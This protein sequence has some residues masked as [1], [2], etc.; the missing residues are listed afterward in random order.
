MKLTNRTDIALRTLI[1]LAINDERIVPIDEIVEKS[2]SH[3]SQVVSAVQTMRK[4]GYL[5]S[6]V[7]RSGGIA[8]ARTPSDISVAEI[9][10]LIEPDFY[11]TECHLR[12]CRVRCTFYM[13]CRLKGE[14]DT[15]L[16]RF[17]DHLEGITLADL[18]G[19]REALLAEVAKS[20]ADRS[21]QREANLA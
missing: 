9:V 2:A 11:L 21:L 13:A 3:R 5:R 14:F 20:P 16:A 4:N 6:V 10:K 18:A 19:N 1:Y 15:A 7:G 8:L 17:F 12:G